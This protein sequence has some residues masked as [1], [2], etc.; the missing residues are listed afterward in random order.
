MVSARNQNFT[1]AYKNFFKK[2]QNHDFEKL[3]CSKA[4]HEIYSD[5]KFQKMYNLGKVYDTNSRFHVK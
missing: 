1:K 3:S 5:L 4:Q 2:P